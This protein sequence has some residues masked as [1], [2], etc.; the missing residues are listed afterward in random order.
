MSY[1]SSVAIAPVGLYVHACVYLVAGPPS[2][3]DE[4]PGD[5]KRGARKK[6]DRA[7]GPAEGEAPSRARRGRPDD[8]SG[9]R[10]HRRDPTP[11]AA[12]P[13]AASTARADGKG[14]G[15]ARTAGGVIRRFRGASGPSEKGRRRPPSCDIT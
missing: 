8:N 4:E 12:T 2:K 15:G 3:L 7:S 13:A 9:G 10:Q 11:A 1:V 5:Q 6:G 14:E